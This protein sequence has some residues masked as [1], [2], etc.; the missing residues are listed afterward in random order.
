MLPLVVS[1]T[2]PV[3]HSLEHRRVE[4]SR[5]L[6]VAAAVVTGEQDATVCGDMLGGVSEFGRAGLETEGA[7][8]G[9]VGDL[10]ERDDHADRRQL[11][12]RK[13]VV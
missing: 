12:D 2:G 9:G 1:D 11:L 3:K 8:G 10:A 13:S 4:P 7:G 6:V 5:V